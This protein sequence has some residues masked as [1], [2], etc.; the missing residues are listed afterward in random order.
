MQKHDLRAFR[1][2]GDTS[3]RSKTNSP[4]SHKILFFPPLAR[5]EKFFLIESKKKSK[6]RKR[7]Q[8]KKKKA[9]QM[10]EFDPFAPPTPPKKNKGHSKQI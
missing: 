5:Q 1:R 6:F 9:E 4:S 8:K 2:Y 3:Y 10:D 7:E